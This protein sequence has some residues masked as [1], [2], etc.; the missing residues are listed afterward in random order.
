MGSQ[1][2][3]TVACGDKFRFAL[4]E[5]VLGAHSEVI[6]LATTVQFCC[7]EKEQAG[8]FPLGQTKPDPPEFEGKHE[9]RL[10]QLRWSPYRKGKWET[11][12]FSDELAQLPA[13]LRCLWESRRTL[14]L[15][16]SGLKIAMLSVD[17]SILPAP[18]AWPLLCEP[19]REG[20]RSISWGSCFTCFLVFGSNPAPSTVPGN[21]CGGSIL[22]SACQ[23]GSSCMQSRQTRKAS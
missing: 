18:L 6:D 23:S 15:G 16:C 17:S 2:I 13:L 5:K 1:P 11:F 3:K 9:L 7:S 19:R 20:K 4:E 10:I 8:Q 14:N 12:W 21:K 22:Q